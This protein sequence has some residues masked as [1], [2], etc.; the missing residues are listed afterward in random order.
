M[1]RVCGARENRAP[2]RGG[3]VADRDDISEPLARFEQ[4]KC[5]LGFVPGNAQAGLLVAALEAAAEKALPHGT[6][7]LRDLRLLLEW[8]GPS[9]QLDFLETHPL[10]RSLDAYEA[11]TPDCFN[12][13]P[14]TAYEH[15]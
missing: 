5:A 7:R 14:K 9:P 4:V 1:E 15:S 10:I 12:P 2:F 6:W 3:F 13:Q 11:L 8:A